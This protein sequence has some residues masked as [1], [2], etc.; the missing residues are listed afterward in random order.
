MTLKFCGNCNPETDPVRVRKV[1]S[2]ATENSTPDIYVNG[3]KRMCLSRKLP[4]GAR[5]VN[6]WEIPALRNS[7]PGKGLA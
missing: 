4:K 5:S 6:A 2:E 7:D 1:M 3:C